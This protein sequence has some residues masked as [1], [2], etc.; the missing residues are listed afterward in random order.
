[1]FKYRSVE[2]SAHVHVLFFLFGGRGRSNLLFLLGLSLFLLR[3]FLLGL[4]LGGGRASSRL[5]F[6]NLE[7]KSNRQYPDSREKAA[8]FLKALPMMRGIVASMGYPAPK[9]RAVMFLT[10]CSNLLIRELGSR[11]RT[12]S[13]RMEPSS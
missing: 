13:G 12:A 8:M 11:L 2:E 4:H 10:P 5:N 1:M 3:F 9:E 7:S 6:L